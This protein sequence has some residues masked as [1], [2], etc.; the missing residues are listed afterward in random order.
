MLFAR[1]SAC[2]VLPLVVIVALLG[3]A[4]H[5]AAPI[6]SRARERLQAHRSAILAGLTLLAGVFVVLLGFTAHTRLSRLTWNRS[7][8][9]QFG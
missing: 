4:G 7:P 2:F 5:R 6:L 9:G 3:S 8:L 1:F